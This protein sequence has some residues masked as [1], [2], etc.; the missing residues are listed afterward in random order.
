MKDK[1]YFTDKEKQIY[2][3]SQGPML[4]YS[5][6]D[7]K[8]LVIGVGVVTRKELVELPYEM[9]REQIDTLKKFNQ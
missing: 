4:S 3:D 7:E 2:I 9:I 8:Q 5:F 6:D 1:I